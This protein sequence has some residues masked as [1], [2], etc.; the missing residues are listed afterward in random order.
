M[1]KIINFVQCPILKNK[2]DISLC[3][4]IQNVVDNMITKNILK[5]DIDFTLSDRDRS[6]FINCIKRTDLEL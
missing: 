2:I 5:N 3:S 1:A 4:D 6:V